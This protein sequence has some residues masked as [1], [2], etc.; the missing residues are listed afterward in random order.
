MPPLKGEK[1][2]S[3]KYNNECGKLCSHFIVTTAVAFADGAL[4]L[5]LP[6]DVT[7]GNGEKFCLVIGQTKVLPYNNNNIIALSPMSMDLFQFN[8]ICNDAFFNSV[9]NHMD[10]IDV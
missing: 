5:T 1:N 10:K 9:Q 7:Y 8:C 2:M 3:C 6:D 4:V